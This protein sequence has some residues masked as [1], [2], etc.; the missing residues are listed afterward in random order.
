MVFKSFYNKNDVEDIYF[1]KL[2]MQLY[3]DNMLQDCIVGYFVCK[4]NLQY[5]FLNMNCISNL[6]MIVVYLGCQVIEYGGVD[7]VLVVNCLKIKMQD[8]WFLDM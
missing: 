3:V 8:I 7:I 5:L 2:L 4:Y 1:L 6:F